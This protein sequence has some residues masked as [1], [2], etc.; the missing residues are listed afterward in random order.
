LWCAWDF[1]DFLFSVDVPFCLMTF[2]FFFGANMPKHNARRG[3]RGVVEK[4]AAQ[5]GFAVGW[6]YEQWIEKT[7][8]KTRVLEAAR[9]FFSSFS[10]LRNSARC[11]G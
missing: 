7:E 11:N 6:G 1:F 9:A 3:N 4:N 2:L 10:Q 5:E 8:A